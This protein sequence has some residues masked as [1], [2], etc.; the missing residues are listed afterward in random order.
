MQA[1]REA[2]PDMQCNDKF[3]VQCVVAPPGAAPKDI[4]PEM[5]RILKRLKILN[6]DR[7]FYFL[8]LS[9]S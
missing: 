7:L 2:P 4:N 5:V 1:Q 9:W 6:L 3:L 8:L